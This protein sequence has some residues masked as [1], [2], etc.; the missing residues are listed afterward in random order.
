MSRLVGMVIL[1]FGAASACN[2]F[3]T[4]PPWVTPHDRDDGRPTFAPEFDPAGAFGALTLLAGSIAVLRA[5]R[6]K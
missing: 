5:R 1:T 2:A 4:L 6:S 3:S